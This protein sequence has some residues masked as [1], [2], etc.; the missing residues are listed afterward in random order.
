MKPTLSRRLAQFVHALR[1]EDLPRPVVEKTKTLFLHGIGMGLAGYDTETAQVAIDMAKNEAPGE[2]TI[3]IDGSK[4]IPTAAAYANAALLH[5]R[6]E[7]DDYQDGLMHPGVVILPAALATSEK[8][9]VTGRNLITAIAAGYE[10]AA[11]LSK[12]FARISVP[13]GF[14]STPVYGPLGVAATVAKLLNLNEDKMVLSLGWAA[15]LSSGLLQCAVSKTP[16]MPIQAGLASRNGI[17]AARLGQVGT[18]VAEDMLE[19]DR[20]FYFA[21]CGSAKDTE[22]ILVGLGKEYRMLD[23]FHKRFPV[24]GGMQSVVACALALVQEHNLSSEN[25]EKVEVRLPP[26]GARYPGVNST[27]P[28]LISAQYCIAVAS[29]HKKVNLRT[30]ADMNNPQVRQI[31]PKI[32]VLPD[33]SISPPGCRISMTLKNKQVFAKD[34]LVTYKDLSFNFDEES[35]HVESLIPEMA[36]PKDRVAKMIELI[37]DMESWTSVADLTRT[38]SNPGRKGERIKLPF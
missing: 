21:F 13:R 4:V 18:S 7:E 20:G 34:M 19:G 9:G 27:E 33:E 10:V 30:V 23:V 22:K 32:T 26:Q 29:V 15:N 36:V 3:L 5:S 1:F 31:M 28:G 16:E 6:C 17:L 37:K 8:E 24:G 11:R 25:I 38:L 35:R 2:A 12:D 14:R